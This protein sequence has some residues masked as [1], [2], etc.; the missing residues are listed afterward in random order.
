MKAIFLA[1]V[2]A[3]SSALG[4]D[5]NAATSIQT[6]T[7]AAAETNITFTVD[8]VTY[9]DVRFKRSTPDTVTFFHSSGVAKVP[10]SKLPPELQKELGYDA[11]KAAAWESAMKKAS[12]DAAKRRNEDAAINAKLQLWNLTVEQVLP[13]GIIVRGIKGDMPP[14]E[15]RGGYLSGRTG[16]AHPVFPNPEKFEIFLVGHPKQSTLADGNQLRVF[17]YREGVVNIDG[18]TLENWI[19]KRE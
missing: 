5:T 11:E 15:M 13:S 1:F 9:K 6:T 10:L 12:D 17:A 16:R 3:A 4:A 7:A 18:Q 8:G 19:Y 14:V 2:F